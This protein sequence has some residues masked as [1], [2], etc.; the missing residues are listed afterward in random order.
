MLLLL[1]RGE[2][3]VGAKGV[4]DQENVGNLGTFSSEISIDVV[5]VA[6]LLESGRIVSYV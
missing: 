4:V 2:R 1:I 3:C 6:E 5:S